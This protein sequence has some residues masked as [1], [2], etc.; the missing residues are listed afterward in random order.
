MVNYIRQ[1]MIIL[2]ISFIGEIFSHYIDL[3][4]PASIYGII[5]MLVG[6][7]TGIVP[8]NMVKDVGHFLVNI[9]SVMFIPATVGLI[10]S[11]DI[12]KDSVLKY[13]V[14]TVVTTVVVMAVSG[15]VTQ[16]FAD[17]RK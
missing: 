12:V 8:Y 6:L 14:I 1:F 10:E 15:R 13:A 16:F 11:W 9:M 3:P 5:L 4:I 7:L 2:L 17:R